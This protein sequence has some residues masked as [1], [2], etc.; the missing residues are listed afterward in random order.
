M[1]GHQGTPLVAETFHGVFHHYLFVNG[2]SARVTD[3]VASNGVVHILDCVPQP[4]YPTAK[5]K[6]AVVQQQG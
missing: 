5:K 4:G 6:S 1:F 2:C 3:L